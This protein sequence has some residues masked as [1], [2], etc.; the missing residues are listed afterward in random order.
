M[1]RRIK[2]HFVL[3]LIAVIELSLPL[4]RGECEVDWLFEAA[5]KKMCAF[6]DTCMYQL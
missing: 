2:V 6:F 5:L 3:I 4:D 1:G